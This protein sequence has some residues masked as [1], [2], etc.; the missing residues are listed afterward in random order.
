MTCP[1]CDRN[2]ERNQFGWA[3]RTKIEDGAHERCLTIEGA[4]TEFVVFQHAKKM[5]DVCIE[6]TLHH[7]N[8]AQIVTAKRIQNG[9]WESA[10]IWAST[11]R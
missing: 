9:R 11:R 4:S 3:C 2:L 10:K 1:Y 5:F 7:G 6:L 8:G